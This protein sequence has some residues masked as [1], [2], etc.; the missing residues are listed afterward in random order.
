MGLG[1]NDRTKSEKYWL[2]RVTYVFVAYAT[3]FLGI[4]EKLPYAHKMPF[5]QA[6]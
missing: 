3:I 5:C 1:L 2:F 6:Y 4:R